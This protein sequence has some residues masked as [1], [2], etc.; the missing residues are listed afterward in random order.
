MLV[1]SM[2]SLLPTS[3]DNGC[4]LDRMDGGM[5]GEVMSDGKVFHEPVSKAFG[6]TIGEAA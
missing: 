1:P 2:D 6:R 3:H 5:M 4:T